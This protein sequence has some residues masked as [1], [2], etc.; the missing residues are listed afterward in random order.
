MVAVMKTIDSNTAK[1]ANTATVRTTVVGLADL[2]VPA[3]HDSPPAVEQEEE[4]GDRAEVPPGDLV[5]DEMLSLA[6][7]FGLDPVS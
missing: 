2:I 3:D 7:Q 6:R 1:T 4:A 5:G